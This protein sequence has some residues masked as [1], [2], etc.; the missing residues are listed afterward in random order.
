MDEDLKKLIESTSAE[1]RRHF[2]VVAERL[3]TKIEAVAEGTNAR[4]DRLDAK[5]DR[6]A[7]DMANEFNEFVP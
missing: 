2:D 1:T 5:V 6:M 3:E 4:V 7:T